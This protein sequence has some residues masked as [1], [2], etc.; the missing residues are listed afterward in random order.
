MWQVQ[1]LATLAHEQ[2]TKVKQTT[3]YT[4]PNIKIHTYV[5]VC[6]FLCMYVYER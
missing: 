3:N 5:C 2:V 4:E 1:H 6:E